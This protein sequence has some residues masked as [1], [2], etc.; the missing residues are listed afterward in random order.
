VVECLG[1]PDHNLGAAKDSL[2]VSLRGSLA[3]VHQ[4]TDMG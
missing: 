4:L 2:S 1:S 3:S